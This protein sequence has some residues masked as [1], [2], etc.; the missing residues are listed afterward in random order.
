M[1][2]DRKGEKI[3][4]KVRKNIKYDDISTGEDPYNTMYDKSAYEA[5]YPDGMAGQMTDNIIAEN[6]LSQVD[7]E[8]HHYQ[9]LTKV[10]DHK[11]D[12]SKIIKV[13]GFIKYSSGN[14]HKKMNTCGWK[15]L[16]ELKDNCVD[17]VPLKDLK[18]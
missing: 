12:E 15:L 13:N 1:L 10:T 14:L 4:E 9:V 8:G 3:M 11:I 18:Q 17:W 5:K 7:S 16:V 6:M 2:S